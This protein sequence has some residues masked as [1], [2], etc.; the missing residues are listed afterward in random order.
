MVNFCAES[1]KQYNFV[2]VDSN[3]WIMSSS[4]ISQ[5]RTCNVYTENEKSIYPTD[6]ARNIYQEL[7]NVSTPD[8]ALTFCNKY[9]LLID[10]NNNLENS[11]FNRTCGVIKDQI[12]TFT[13][14]LKNSRYYLWKKLYNGHH[15]YIS[16]PYCNSCKGKS[17][18]PIWLLTTD[19]GLRVISYTI[20]SKEKLNSIPKTD[21]TRK[22]TRIIIKFNPKIDC[23][24]YNHFLY[25]KQA[26]LILDT[27][28]AL[29]KSEKEPKECFS[30]WRE[31]LTHIPHFLNYSTI[32]LSLEYSLWAEGSETMFQSYPIYY[33]I[34]KSL[35]QDI[36]T[37]NKT[38][39][40]ILKDTNTFPASYYL[41]YKFCFQKLGPYDDSLK[42]KL[43][44]NPSDFK[45]LAQ[46]LFN[47]IAEFH[48]KEIPRLVLLS[49]NY[50]NLKG[51]SF[52]SLADALI[53]QKYIDLSAD[54]TLKRCADE[55]C[56]LLFLP[57][58]KRGQKYCCP[59]CCKK[60]NDRKYVRN[61]RADLKAAENK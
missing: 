6:S 34:Y 55:F 32:M 25:Y 36:F 23:M 19:K 15:L 20:A 2:T 43:L 53:F 54:H 4:P 52:P 21:I 35:T 48:L 30:E 51:Y 26:L 41:L 18:Y 24:D 60:A 37:E 11:R 59:E 5:K 9:G 17:L 28:Y 57:M 3:R 44:N 39:P 8:D 13:T 56:N 42:E 16:E 10:P 33:F 22:D 12:D 38:Y 7:E 58:K 31:L 14:P 50:A 29:I 61:K 27:L 40:Q 49:D 47:D 45:D 46:N 1:S